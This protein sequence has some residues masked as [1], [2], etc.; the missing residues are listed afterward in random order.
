M[1][2]TNCFDACDGACSAHAV[3]RWVR[4]EQPPP[5]RLDGGLYK[6]AG[7]KTTAVSAAHY[8][9]CDDVS[10]SPRALY[11][12]KPDGCALEPFS[13]SASCAA[14]RGRQLLFAGDSTIWQLF[15]S[16]VLLHGGRLGRNAGHISTASEL[17]ASLCG[18]GVR[19]VF[20]RTDLLL[21]TTHHWEYTMAR[22]ADTTI[23]G[24]AFVQRALD[25][26]LVVFG[27]G[28][29]LPRVMDRLNKLGAPEDW[30]KR[31]AFFARNLNHTLS[32]A[33]RM[34]AARGRDPASLVLVGA[35]I[36][37][38]GCSRFG[39]PISLAASVGTA[40]EAAPR[41]QYT[42]RWQA[43]PVYNQVAHWLAR[44]A[45]ARFVDVAAPSAQRPDAAMA[46]FQPNAGAMDEDCLHFCLPGP[47]DTWS[48]L[49]FN[50]WS[51]PAL[52]QRIANGGAEPGS[53]RWFA[54]NATKWVGERASAHHME[55]CRR[56][57][58]CIDAVVSREWWWPFVNLSAHRPRTDGAPNAK[59]AGRKS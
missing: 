6:L 2:P 12:W 30:P 5:Y 21:W 35:T 31:D 41:N 10:P 33:L 45:G 34:R 14:M 39:E 54:V 16:F 40:A 4:R 19:A 8:G 29:H 59:A 57:G 24:A 3:G 20:V 49:L 27:I 22:R 23:K 18:D 26:D 58:T 7:M 32:R 17:T 38:S 53:G 36:P 50:L 37:V 15:L 51:L 13:A 11:D 56:S 25:A 28:H 47:V 9:R 46:R 44:S 1:A 42:S 52:Q 43:M 48:Q 55:G